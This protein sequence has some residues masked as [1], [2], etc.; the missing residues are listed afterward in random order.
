MRDN[1]KYDAN[2]NNNTRNYGK[3]YATT[4]QYQTPSTSDDNAKDASMESEQAK[5]SGTEC[6][7]S[8]D[9]A[10]GILLAP[11]GLIIT[12]VIILWAILIYHCKRDEEF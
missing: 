7:D 4:T 9:D 10:V 11:T 3:K 8:G 5:D 12:R 2:F 1:N 6:Y